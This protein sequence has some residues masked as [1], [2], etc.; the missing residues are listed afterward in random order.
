MALDD[1]IDMSNIEVNLMNLV[2]FT[3]AEKTALSINEFINLARAQGSSDDSIKG[4][5][6]KDLEEGGR[7]FGDFRS[8]IRA[9]SNGII[10]RMSDSAQWAEDI[11]VEKYRWVAVLVNTCPDCILRHG[12]VKT[13]EQW[14]EE[15]LPRAGMTVCKDNCKCKL[16]NADVSILEPIRRSKR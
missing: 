2:L 7:L 3:K 9:T 1:F 5:L 8:S 16:I 13:M 11:D 4:Y 12:D 10:N 15:G 14:E 6:L